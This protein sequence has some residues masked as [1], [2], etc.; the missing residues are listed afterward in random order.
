MRQAVALFNIIYRMHK[1]DL[2]SS[3]L[4]ESF[5]GLKYE[6]IVYSRKFGVGQISGFYNDEIIV[7]FSNLRKRFSL[8]DKEIR[9]IPADYFMERS[10]IVKISYKGKEMSYADYKK[11]ANLTK[12]GIREEKESYATLREVADILGISKAELFKSIA[13]NSIQTKTF[14]RSVMIHRED[15]LKLNKKFSRDKKS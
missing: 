3:P 15:I 1:F 14:G 6:D 8:E 7:R 12:S 13:M 11:K 10:K 5:K 4:F 2:D 9:K